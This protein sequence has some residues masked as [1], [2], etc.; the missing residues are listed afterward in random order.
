MAMGRG[1]IRPPRGACVPFCVPRSNSLDRASR[2]F[3]TAGQLQDRAIRRTSAPL[4]GLHARE[5][6]EGCYADA[7]DTRPHVLLHQAA[8]SFIRGKQMNLIRIKQN[9]E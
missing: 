1:C 2:A 7:A 6:A 3:T 5:A 9:S 8:S 4:P